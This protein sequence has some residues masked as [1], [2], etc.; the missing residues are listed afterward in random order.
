M[1]LN[2]FTQLALTDTP[3]NALQQ[4]ASMGSSAFNGLQSSYMN[5]IK[6]RY[7][8][9]AYAKSLEAS[10]LS[11]TAQ[12]IKNQYMPS[13]MQATIQKTRAGTQLPSRYAIA[14]SY[15]NGNYIRYDKLFGQYD[16]I[17]GQT[18]SILK[19]GA[20][21][22]N[23]QS[24]VNQQPPPQ[25]SQYT[26]QQQG[27]GTAQQQQPQ[28]P[29]QQAL[30]VNTANPISIGGNQNLQQS[31]GVPSPS[32]AFS[33]QVSS[34]LPQ[35]PASPFQ[36]LLFNSAI[37]QPTQ[38]IRNYISA[39]NN[40]SSLVSSPSQES[41][42]ALQ[43]RGMGSASLNSISAPLV[44]VASE[45][46]GAFG[47]AQLQDDIASYKLSG[48][49]Q[50]KEKLVNLYALRTVQAELGA[51]ISRMTLSK[52]AG[53]RSTAIFMKKLYVNL[54]EIPFNMPRD[55]QA[56]GVQ[57]SIAYSNVM[58]NAADLETASGFK[59]KL[60]PNTSLKS[61]VITLPKNTQ[62][63]LSGAKSMSQYSNI[64]YVPH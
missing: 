10:D 7:Q 38:G 1:P 61:G 4:G 23:T 28:S 62:N 3:L 51:D 42:Q 14:S 21:P 44:T 35:N 20:S 64:G 52:N 36:K 5:A 50:L 24:N 22:L 6:N 45:Y 53:I 39:D 59:I 33:Q 9:Q 25:Q 58:K 15:A 56:A 43:Y 47:K 26:P 55:V 32:S 12:S 60:P 48:N 30:P 37:R 63:V 27:Y 41:Q 40:G 57:R 49:P 46:G 18:G 34:S 54:P 29:P 31:T 13:L 19:S 16:L 2:A 17:D 11:N 8:K